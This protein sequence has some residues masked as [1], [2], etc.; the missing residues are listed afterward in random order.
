MKSMIDTSEQGQTRAMTD[1]D[2]RIQ[3][4]KQ[5][6]GGL[7]QNLDSRISEVGIYNYTILLQSIV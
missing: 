7:E 1:L 2:V 4:L 6:I 3:S 5:K